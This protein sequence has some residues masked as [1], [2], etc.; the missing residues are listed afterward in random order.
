M[1]VIPSDPRQLITFAQNHRAVWA[2]NAQQIG[3]S[4]QQLTVFDQA[5]DDAA[6]ALGNAEKARIASKTA[7]QSFQQNSRTL[8]AAAGEIVRSVKTYAENNGN[9]NVYDLA[10]IPAPSPRG[11][12]QPPAK[13]TAITASLTP[14]GFITLRWK[15]SNPAGVSGVVYTVYRAVGNSGEFTFLDAVGEKTF[16][17]ETVP[18]DAGPVVYKI[19]PKRGRQTGP[20]SDLF[21]VRFGITPTGGAF[22]RS[23]STEKVK[24]AA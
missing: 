1:P 2:A 19:V 21:T 18:S 8:R 10:Q 9:P 16:T 20:S 15:A 7:T 4:S 14:E 24:M 17:D 23:T 22:V 3:V 5:L 11:P 12:A 13:P 6:D